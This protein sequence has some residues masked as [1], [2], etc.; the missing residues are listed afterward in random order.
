MYCVVVLLCIVVAVVGGKND[1]RTMTEQ[2]DTRSNK[3]NKRHMDFVV[4][5][6]TLVLYVYEDNQKSTNS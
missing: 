1:M 2:N 6:M 3:T 5:R 4:N